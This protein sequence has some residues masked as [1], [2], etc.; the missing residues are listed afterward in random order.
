MNEHPPTS[1]SPS[2]HRAARQGSFLAQYGVYIALAVLA[3]LLAAHWWTAHS[4]IAALRTELAQRLKGADELNTETKL[5][6]KS[7]QEGTKELQ[8]K[9]SVLESKQLEAQ[10]QQ[11]ALDQLY[12]QLSRSR[13][14]WALAEIEQVLS[15]ASQQLQLAGNVQGA[16]IAL[17]NADNRLASSDAPQFITIRRA[18]AKDL[19]RLKSVPS[20]DL[21]GLAL[22]LDN[23][24]AQIDSMPLLSNEKPVAP[25]RTAAKAV[26]GAGKGTAAKPNENAGWLAGVSDTWHRWTDE[27][28]TEVSQLIRVRNVESSDALL[29]SPTQTY[30]VRENLKL[31]VLNARLALLSRNE[32]AFRSDLAAA[33]EAIARY[34]DTR[35]RQTQTTQALLRQL[36]SSNLS[37]E[38]PSL[39]ESLNAVRNY[40]AKP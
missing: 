34:F 5:L 24:V 28:W 37:I 14:D 31:R 22:R 2:A 9:V 27:M 10:S 32:A 3:L 36:Q 25:A 21:T 29:L 6:V 1:A 33:Q 17:Q 20:V 23:V 35:A 26:P 8:S 30:Y 4:Q 16:L 19:D 18:I 11:L 40:K 39:A 12:Q 7:V 38:M 15:T 13:D